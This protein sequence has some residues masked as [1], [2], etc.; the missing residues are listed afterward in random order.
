MLLECFSVSKWSFSNV[1]FC[2]EFSLPYSIPPS[3][4][5]IEFLQE[6]C[7]SLDK[8]NFRT[9]RISIIYSCADK[10]LHPCIPKMALFLSSSWFLFEC[11]QSY[12]HW[13]WSKYLEEKRKHSSYRLSWVLLFMRWYLKWAFVS[14]SAFGSNHPETASLCKALFFVSIPALNLNLAFTSNTSFL[15]TPHLEVNS[16]QELFYSI[17]EETL[18]IE[19]WYIWQ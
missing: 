19:K 14:F 9:S 18:K 7:P 10:V 2:M 1:L 13:N 12:L 15:V 11:F 4:I 6:N 3:I 5:I 16:W 17:F 8:I